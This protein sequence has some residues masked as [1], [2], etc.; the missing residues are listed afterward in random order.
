MVNATTHAG[1]MDFGPEWRRGASQSVRAEGYRERWDL[2]T[3]THAK[4]SIGYLG[5][6]AFRLIESRFS[7][8]EMLYATCNVRLL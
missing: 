1:G 8:Q 7:W 5:D 6:P 4:A 3:Q 2:Q